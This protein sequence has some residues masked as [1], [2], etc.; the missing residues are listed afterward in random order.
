[1][2]KITNF[3][4]SQGMINE[5]QNMMKAPHPII[6]FEKLD[7]FTVSFNLMNINRLQS[8]MIC[9]LKDSYVQ[10]S[11]RYVKNTKD[12]FQE[13]NIDNE[14]LKEE[15]VNLVEKTMD[16]YTRMTEI[17]EESKGK[18]RTTVADYKHGIPIEDARYILPLSAKTNM[19][20]TMSGDKFGTFIAL[21]SHYSKTIFKD[22]YDEL[23]DI[24]E[25]SGI[26]KVIMN[27]Y[28]PKIINLFA[29]NATELLNVSSNNRI[30]VD[31]E[32]INAI[33]R[34]ILMSTTADPSKKVEEKYPTLDDREALIKRVAGYG[35]TSVLEQYRFNSIMKCSLVTLHQLIRHRMVNIKPISLDNMVK[36]ISGREHIIPNTIKR[37]I[38]IEEYEALVQ[39]WRILNLRLIK[40]GITN[41]SPL[42]TILNGDEIV[43]NFTTNIRADEEFLNKRLCVNAQWEIRRLAKDRVTKLRETELGFI[44]EKFAK[45]DCALPKGC[46]EGAYSCSKKVRE[47]A[48]AVKKNG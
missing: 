8:T 10:Q 42:L 45:P 37:S 35:H 7:I 24:L 31:K 46:Q 23:C 29:S 30:E 9:L 25:M 3:T 43:F 11:Q 1:M 18:S 6:Y 39:E 48:K 34:G 44:Y 36:M 32:G 20:V 5:I 12:S 33:C 38:F 40:S 41:E 47:A 28:D 2:K 15:Y 26:D 13:L 19:S 4:M 22:L 21:L 17:K 16:L 14:L 27:Y